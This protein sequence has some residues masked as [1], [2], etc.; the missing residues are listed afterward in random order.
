MRA[1]QKAVK[2]G[3]TAMIIVPGSRYPYAAGD[4][5]YEAAGKKGS[6]AKRNGSGE[7][8]RQTA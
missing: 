1:L 3:G 7:Q 2:Q 4:L 6:A 5:F 8:R